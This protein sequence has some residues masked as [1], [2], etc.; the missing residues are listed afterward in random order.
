MPVIE[1][2][3][4]D[5]RNLTI[6]SPPVNTVLFDLERDL[7]ENI[8][9]EL[10]NDISDPEDIIWTGTID[11]AIIKMMIIGIQIDDEIREK[12]VNFIKEKSQPGNFPLVMLGDMS[13]LAILGEQQEISAGLKESFKS[14]ILNLNDPKEIVFRAVQLKRLGVELRLPDEIVGSLALEAED[15]ASYAARQITLKELGYNVKFS[16]EDIRIRTDSLKMVIELKRLA[17]LVYM[18]ARLRIMTA[19]SVSIRNGKYYFDEE[20]DFNFD[21]EAI[22]E[23]RLF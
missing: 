21:E 16:N 19:K 12:Y 8:R 20:E 13:S 6:E 3:P 9:Q 17:P 18:A 23:L 22:P 10:A 1:N 5:I 14:N 2:Q 15:A 4:L 7:P 11:P